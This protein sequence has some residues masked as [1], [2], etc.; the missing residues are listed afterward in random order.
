MLKKDLVVHST[1]ANQVYQHLK[2]RIIN[3]EL[4]PG[5]RLIVSHIAAELGTS[6]TPV[7]EALTSLTKDGLVEMIPHKG[8]CVAKPTRKNFEDLFVVR[9]VLEGL[10]VRLAASRLTPADIQTLDELIDRGDSILS[11]GEA[12]SWIEMDMKLHGFIAQKSGNELL[13]EIL[14]GIQDRI[15]I[16]RLLT[17]GWPDGV[18][19]ASQEH[20][21]IVSALRR[22]DVEG[23]EKLM[24]EHIENTLR[25]GLENEE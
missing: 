17:V 13:I 16:F 15:H 6:L 19:R 2:K 10:S 11:A 12:E 7:R 25:V 24:M 9:K 8:A 14:S 21:A 5:T 1:L 4:K 20:Q 22:G 3:Q 23:A 18:K